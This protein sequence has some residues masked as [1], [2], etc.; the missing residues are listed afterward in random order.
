LPLEHL[1]EITTST[2]IPFLSLERT[3]RSGL[4]SGQISQTEDLFPGRSGHLSKYGHQ[5]AAKS[6][7]QF[8]FHHFWKY[9]AKETPQQLAEE[10]GKTVF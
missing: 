1:E 2:Q 9:E 3:F 5:E 4:E 10:P 6:L 7:Q 8:L